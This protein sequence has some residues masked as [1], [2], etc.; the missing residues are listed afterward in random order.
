MLINF[1]KY[2]VFVLTHPYTLL[3]QLNEKNLISIKKKKR[4]GSFPCTVGPCKLVGF[5]CQITF[6]KPTWKLFF[7]WV[8]WDFAGGINFANSVATNIYLFSLQDHRVLLI[9]MG[10]RTELTSKP[11]LTKQQH[12]LGLGYSWDVPSTD[13]TRHSPAPELAHHPKQ[14]GFVQSTLWEQSL[15]CS[16]C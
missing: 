1:V 2:S 11:A 5:Q 15:K 7:Q 13:T 8:G 14:G 4:V 12:S 10:G 16:N 9:Q 3:K 6:L